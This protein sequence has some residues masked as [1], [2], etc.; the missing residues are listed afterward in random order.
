MQPER[1][2]HQTSI[3]RVGH[4]V[5]L[6]AISRRLREK[7]DHLVHGVCAA[8]LVVQIGSVSPAD[9]S[10]DPGDPFSQGYGAAKAEGRYRIMSKNGAPEIAQPYDVAMQCHLQSPY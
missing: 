10:P 8:A 7:V 2:R 5:E 4:C 9:W 1:D 3:C 6:D